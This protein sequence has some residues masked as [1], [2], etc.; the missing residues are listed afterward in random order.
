MT[1]VNLNEGPTDI[2]ASLDR[3]F[4]AE[5]LDLESGK[6][7]RYATITKL[8]PIMQL[9]IQRQGFDAQRAESFI[10]K[11]HVQL[12]ETIYLD[13]YVTS[14]SPALLRARKASWAFKTR[15]RKLQEKRLKLTVTSSGMTGP[16]LLE[17][18]YV[19]VSKVSK[20][21]PPPEGLA[22]ELLQRAQNCRA[23]IE[24]ID[25]RLSE[26][27]GELNALFA[28]MQALPYSLAAVFV[29]RGGVRSGHYWIYIRD[30]ESGAWRKYED[31]TVQKVLDTKE[32]FGERD[33][34]RDGAPYFV[35]YVDEQR[36]TE[37]V[38]A[39]H[40]IEPVATVEDLGDVPV[41]DVEMDEAPEPTPVGPAPP[42]PPRPAS[43]RGRA[44]TF[45]AG[46]EGVELIEEAQ[47]RD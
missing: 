13:R 29:H 27:Q 1:T 22:D 34:E 38:E 10:L 42:L 36:K 11:H 33:P 20:E 21:V 31:Q 39:L 30:F 3:S 44:K 2:Y 46:A 45:Y 28:N 6:T 37:I 19:W 5:E 18:T 9:Y 4:D 26:L 8:P 17:E 32:I 40:R 47:E 7:F 41:P 24:R 16:E 12:D 35:V 14:S 23:F 25:K 43:A 15:I